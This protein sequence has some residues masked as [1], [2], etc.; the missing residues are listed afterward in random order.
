MTDSCSLRIVLDAQRSNSGY[1]IF[2]AFFRFSIH[3]ESIAH[4]TRLELPITTRE[5]TNPR[6]K[7]L[8]NHG[9][10]Q[11]PTRCLG[12]SGPKVKAA[13]DHRRHPQAGG[14]PTGSSPG[15]PYL[16]AG[17]NRWIRYCAVSRRNTKLVMS[18][19]TIRKECQQTTFVTISYSVWTKRRGR[20]MVETRYV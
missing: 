14:G 11:V 19:F 17:M 18:T 6:Q 3:S 9:P 2:R 10:V 1:L 13:C 15:F 8:P 16:K 7:N 5:K 4:P 12:N 20:R